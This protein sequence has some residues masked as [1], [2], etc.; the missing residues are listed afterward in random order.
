MLLLAAFCI[1]GFQVVKHILQLP[2]RPTNDKL[3]QKGS[4]FTLDFLIPEGTYIDEKMT[5]GAVI[6]IR[7]QKKTS[8]YDALLRSIADLIPGRYRF[9]ADFILFVFWTFLFM[10]FFRVFTFM[11]Y[12]SALRLSLLF[13]GGVYYFLPDFSPGK[14]DD[15][16]FIGIPL[17]III[18]RAYMSWRG[19]KRNS[20]D[21]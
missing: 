5:I 20:V 17:A 18:L 6:K 1:G 15:A 13:G 16:V 10:T 4:D 7:T 19:K 3:H 21:I 11:R 9:G 14:I 2:F 12:G 8:L